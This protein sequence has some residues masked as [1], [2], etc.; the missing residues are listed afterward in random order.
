LGH[1]AP[2]FPGLC[3]IF[4]AF[5]ER[6]AIFGSDQTVCRSVSHWALCYNS[7][8]LGY[9][10][11]IQIMI[12]SLQEP[13]AIEYMARA[14]RL[15][16][17]GLYSTH[18]N[19]RVGC[20][21]VKDGRI[22][23]EGWHVLAG[24]GHAEVNALA[25]AGAEARGA[26]AYVTLEPCNH[27]GKTPPCTRALVEA[28]I[29]AVVSAME[30]PNPLVAGEGHRMLETA[31]IEVQ[32]GILEAQS[33]EL[34]PGFVKRMETGLPWV[35]CKSAMSVDGRTAMASGES[36]WITGSPARQDVQKLRARSGAI[37]TGIGSV[38][39]DDP[40]LTVRPETWPDSDEGGQFWPPGIEP[41]Q[42]LR[43]V[44]D[45]R[46]RMPPQAKMLRLPGDTLIVCTVNDQKKRQLLEAGGAE[47]LCLESETAA[48]D[49]PALLKLLAHRE[50]NEVLVESG[51][52]TNGAFVKAGLVDE[53]IVYMAP[54]L[55]GSG[56][57]PLLALPH[58]DSMSDRI[59]LELKDSR[60][61]GD[62]IRFTYGFVKN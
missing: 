43:V 26:T 12:S 44:L 28:G 50:I 30:D 51:A 35:R 1:I 21:I 11:Y 8:F 36:Q 47:V 58:I 19:P 16:R 20:V 6:K 32:S 53:W 25:A 57:R 34:N 18:P 17:R 41:I 14:I 38:L 33:R 2:Y 60:Q 54:V 3:R 24:Q 55:M 22:V 29:A 46:L 52:I 31:G 37:I 62:D 56:A 40:S 61:I 49:L 10:V 15:A 23:G 13:E 39:A 4:P 59:R 7:P 9:S 45:S 42:P 5:I 48:V 27:Q